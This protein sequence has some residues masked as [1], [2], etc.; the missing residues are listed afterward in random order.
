M[1]RDGKL[2]RNLWD[3]KEMQMERFSSTLLDDIRSMPQA[4]ATA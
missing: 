4:A 1:A 3:W 2:E